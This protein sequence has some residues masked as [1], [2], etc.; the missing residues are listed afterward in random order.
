ML[1]VFGQTEVRRA[2][3][4]EE[5]MRSPALYRF[6]IEIQGHT[7]GREARRREEKKDE[8]EKEEGGVH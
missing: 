5:A 6:D 7:S 4:K 1:D 8:R 3:E 2:R